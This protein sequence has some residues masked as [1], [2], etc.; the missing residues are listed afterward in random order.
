M[1][2]KYRATRRNLF[3]APQDVKGNSKETDPDIGQNASSPTKNNVQKKS[4]QRPR[5]SCTL[6]GELWAAWRTSDCHARR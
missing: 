5:V 6:P 3:D 4:F 2:P 1:T